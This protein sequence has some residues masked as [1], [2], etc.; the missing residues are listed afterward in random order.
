[1]PAAPLV[2]VCWSTLPEIVQCGLCVHGAKVAEKTARAIQLITGTTRNDL[3]GTLDVTGSA[4]INLVQAIVPASAAGTGGKVFVRLT[5]E[6]PVPWFDLEVPSRVP[7][8]LF[9]S[10][11]SE[12]HMWRSA[13][14][15][16]SKAISAVFQKLM[17]KPQF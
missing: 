7:W 14:G 2:S 15:D 12:H 11:M 5:A 9:M 8:G 1:M 3:A 6:T 16:L 13:Q 17:F 10:V 4:I